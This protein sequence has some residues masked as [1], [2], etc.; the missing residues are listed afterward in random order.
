MLVTS[1]TSG[2]NPLTK[3][4]HE[5]ALPLS[6]APLLLGVS[7]AGSTSM[8]ASLT[9]APFICSTAACKAMRKTL[10]STHL[11]KIEPPL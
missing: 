11:C 5:R 10:L 4:L 1:P 8:R 6:T 3:M 2:P 9:S 7:R